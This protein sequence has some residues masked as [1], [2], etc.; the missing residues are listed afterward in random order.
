MSPVPLKKQSRAGTSM[1][2]RRG[3]PVE[4]VVEPITV[5]RFWFVLLHVAVD[6]VGVGSVAGVVSLESCTE[7]I[8]TC[9]TEYFECMV[10]IA[11]ARVER[12]VILMPERTLIC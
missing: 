9:G 5:S 8:I 3:S 7:V 1:R 10:V 4:R 6:G 2:K 11:S 12:D